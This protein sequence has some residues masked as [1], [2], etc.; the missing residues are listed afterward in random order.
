MPL[1]EKIKSQ[2]NYEFFLLYFIITLVLVFF[3][4]LPLLNLLENDKKITIIALFGNSL[5]IS[6]IIVAIVDLINLISSKRSSFLMPFLNMTLSITLFLLM[7][8][9]FVN[10]FFDIIYVWRHS[11]LYQPLVYK[12]VAIWAGQSGSIMT[13]MV[14]NSLV[15]FFYRFKTSITE[16]DQKDDPVYVLSCIFGLV[17]LIIFLLIKV[18][19]PSPSL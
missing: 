3:L 1:M 15:L 10:D 12:I 6:I 14:F 5:I 9:C 2:R 13:W 4:F 16:N 19:S 11:N 18:N 8:Y 7:I 17:I